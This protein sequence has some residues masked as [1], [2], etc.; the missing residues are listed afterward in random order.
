MSIRFR[1][2]ALLLLLAV[3]VVCKARAAEGVYR[4]AIVPQQP[5]T[6]VLRLWS[7]LVQQ[8]RERTGIPLEF[9]TYANIERFHAAVAD[10]RDDFVYLNPKQY[11]RARAIQG[12][13]PLVRE[14]DRRIRGI[15]V[16]RR[17]SPIHA[18]RELEGADIAFPAPSAFAASILVRSWLSGQGIAFAPHY[19]RSHDSVYLNVARG[20]CPAG[21][22]IPRTLNMQPPAVRKALRV[23]VTTPAFTPHALAVHPRVPRAIAAAVQQALVSMEDREAG[24][25]ALRRLAITGW[26]RARDEDWNDVRQLHTEASP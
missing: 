3:G 22:G 21:G 14:R 20:L 26:M 11:L 13:T 23:L 7:P 9:V 15:L 1:P 25:A 19:V 17:D 8:L 2:I 12:Y 10:G 6:T 4:L 5:P 16:V 24:K 18:A